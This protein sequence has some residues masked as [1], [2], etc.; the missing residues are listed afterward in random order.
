MNKFAEMMSNERQ[1][2]I[3]EELYTVEHDDVHNHGDLADAAACYAATPQWIF[4]GSKPTSYK[5]LIPLWPW[6]EQWY[7]KHKHERKRQLIIAG[8][9]IIAELERLERL[10]EKD[11]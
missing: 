3:E 5:K 6:D 8:A 7:K 4:K 2:Q 10:E 1:R 11:V 9:L